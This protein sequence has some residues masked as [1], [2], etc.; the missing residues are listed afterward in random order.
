MV[1]SLGKRYLLLVC[2]FVFSFIIFTY[3]VFQG[4]FTSFD[5]LVN[6]SLVLNISSPL[7]IFSRV[8]AYFYIPL[9]IINLYLFGLF[10][11]RRRKYE[12]LMILTSFSGAIASELILKPIFSVQC[13]TLVDGNLV[14]R[15]EVIGFLQALQS[16]GL[17]ETC[18][19]SSHAASYVVFCGYL[20]FLAHKFIKVKWQRFI[21]MFT[22]L[23]IIIVIGPSRLYLH[24]HWFSDII[25]G[26]LLGFALLFLILGVHRLS[27]SKQVQK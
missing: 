21:T 6:R 14:G 22:L 3:L 12:A 1:S 11:S 2:I 19:P 23:S 4:L 9:V 8:L 27:V 16:I 7:Y 10:I 26:Y 24:V 25:A 13:P 5:Q 20:A 18:Y 15:A 17:I